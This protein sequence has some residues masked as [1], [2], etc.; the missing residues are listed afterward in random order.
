MWG[1]YALAIR[2]AN[3]DIIY[4][5]YASVGGC[6]PSFP[7]AY[8]PT[9][10]IAAVT[11]AT[12]YTWSSS[13]GTLLSG[14]NTLGATFDFS[15]VPNNSIVSVCV[16]PTGPACT[17]PQT[18]FDVRV[19]NVPENCSNGI[20]DDGDGL[21]DCADCEECAS[22]VACGDN[23]NDGIG[24]FCDLDDD[25]D[26]IPDLDECPAS[27]YG[28]NLITNGD[29]EDGYANW[30]S[31][32]N[33]GRNNNAPTSDGRSEQGWIAISG[34]AS[35]NGDCGAYYNYN[36]LTPTGSTL[37]SD[38]LGTGANVVTTLACNTDQDRC[39]AER[40]PD[41]TSGSGLSLSLHRP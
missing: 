20:D 14:Q 37:I 16:Q 11:N 8:S 41:H 1:V 38:P 12:G 3:D 22:S 27:T 33:R 32:F 10:S 9:F 24:D 2:D 21:I 25:N 17:A 18:C 15:A 23:D 31:Y 34:C 7:Q 26:G 6:I 35:D 28:P 4:P 40:L 30:T 5:G 39:Y 19:L 36:G 29:F 13:L